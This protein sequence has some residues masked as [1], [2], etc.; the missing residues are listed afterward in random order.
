MGAEAARIATG[1]QAPADRLVA[2]LRAVAAG[3]RAAFA[4]LYTQTAAQLFG[5]ALRMLRQ[6]DRAEDVLQES[7]VAIWQRASDYDP[8]KGSPMT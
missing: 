3:D 7:F 2:L 1:Q 5:I 8:A 4:A 6:R